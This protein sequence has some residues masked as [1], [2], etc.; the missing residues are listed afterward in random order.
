MTSQKKSHPLT[1]VGWGPIRWAEVLKPNEWRVPMY[2]KDIHYTIYVG[3]GLVRHY[4]NKTLP[5][6]LKSKMAMITAYWI[7]NHPKLIND[8]TSDD[9]VGFGFATGM[10]FYRNTYPAVF[11]D[12][13]WRISESYYTVIVDDELLFSMRG[14]HDTGREG[15][16][17]S[18]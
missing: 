7:N 3:N 18:S 6:P 13:G 14:Q 17:K 8:I 9:L 15:E 5:D 1:D 2:H 16:E 4:T 12:V 10:C 11:C